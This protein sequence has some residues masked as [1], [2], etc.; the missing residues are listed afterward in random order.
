[1][2]VQIQAVP[3]AVGQSHLPFMQDVAQAI[4]RPGNDI[5]FAARAGIDV[6]ML[7]LEDHLQLMAVFG[8]IEN[9]I[10]HTGS[11]SLA[12]GHNLVFRQHFTV[13]FLQKLMDPRAVH[14]IFAAAGKLARSKTLMMRRRQA[15]N[16]GDHVDDVHPEAVD[17]FVEPESHHLVQRLAQLRI[18]PVQIGLL[19]REEMQVIFAGSLIQLP[20]R[21]AEDR[22]PVVRQLAVW[23]ARTPDIIVAV[24]IVLGGA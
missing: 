19:A 17:P 10:L 8:G 12:D 2:V 6:H 5:P 15:F 20:G 14:V 21:S 3:A 1:M 4:K 7:E 18:L 24:R 9:G 22:A 11:R 16:L 23:T 13:H